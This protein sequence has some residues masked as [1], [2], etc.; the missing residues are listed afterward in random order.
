MNAA[1]RSVACPKCGKRVYLKGWANYC[2]DC[3]TL[4]VFDGERAYAGDT[5]LRVIFLGD[6][7]NIRGILNDLAEKRKE[8]K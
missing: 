4:I 8:E 1:T 2:A 6:I 3:K 5:P 7:E